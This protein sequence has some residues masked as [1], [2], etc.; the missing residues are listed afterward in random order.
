MSAEFIQR[1]RKLLEGRALARPKIL[2]GSARA[3]PSRKTIRY[4]PLAIR[5]P[6]ASSVPPKSLPFASP[7]ASIVFASP[8]SMSAYRR[9]CKPELLLGVGQG[10]EPRK[11]RSRHKFGR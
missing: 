3:L 9:N 7:F 10:N 8:G 2:N 11:A 1:L 6:S 5:F 4:S